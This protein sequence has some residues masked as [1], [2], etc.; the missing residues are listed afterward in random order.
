MTRRIAARLLMAGSLVT[1]GL[2]TTAPP[3][4]ADFHFMK[5]TE[6]SDGTTIDPLAEFVELQMY[7]SGQNLVGGHHLRTYDSSGNLFQDFTLD[8]NVPGGDDQR[9]ILIGTM[10]VGGR[11]LTE[12]LNI[13][14]NGAV[15]FENVDCVAWGSITN[16]GTLTSPVTAPFPTAMPTEFSLQRK[17]S[18]NC[19]T[20]LENADDTNNSATDFEAAAATPRSNSVTPTETPCAP[21]TVG[22]KPILQSL[23]AKVRGSRAIISGK[24]LPP[25]PGKRVVLTF[26]AN[27]SPLRKISKKSATL[28]ADSRFKKG[29]RVPT[30]ST[31]CRVKVAFEG[32]PMGKKTFRC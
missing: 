19:P 17:I 31:R 22:G 14:G 3:A 30:D 2:V 28:N 23:K 24:I 13:P 21:G 18:P 15:C 16:L 9:T 8:S 7:S 10:S 32:D 12:S 1:G 26:F 4:S 27:G 6:V 5:I 29:F 25:A 20:S 11:D